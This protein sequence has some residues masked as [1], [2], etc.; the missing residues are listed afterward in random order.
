MNSCQGSFD[1]LIEATLY[2]NPIAVYIIKEKK[3]AVVTLDAI[4]LMDKVEISMVTQSWV[5]DHSTLCEAL[6]PF[7][8][9]HQSFKGAKKNFPIQGL[10]NGSD[11]LEKIIGKTFCFPSC[12]QPS[13]PS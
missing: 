1:K 3:S 7:D 8:H 11:P 4:Y 13:P 12:P 6:S 10:R 2:I 9:H 5:T